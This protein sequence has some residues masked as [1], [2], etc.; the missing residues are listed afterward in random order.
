MKTSEEHDSLEIIRRIKSGDK[1]AFEL[2]IKQ[3]EKLVFHIVYRMIPEQREKE[4]ICQ[5]IFI[6]IYQN[7]DTF[8]FRSKVS[9]WIGAIAYNTCLNYTQKKRALLFN[10]HTPQGITLDSINGHM[11]PPDKY[12]EEQDLKNQ[13][14]SAVESLP[15]IYRTAISL[16][17]VEGMSYNEISQIMDLP[18]GTVKS[19]LFRARKKLKEMLT[20]KYREEPLWNVT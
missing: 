2:F 6:K 16:Y 18:E 1:Q 3:Y 9:T 15:Q 8:Q 19:Y 13:I 20:I 4:D 10:D 11:H 7:L 17:H 12:T 14:Q 5:D